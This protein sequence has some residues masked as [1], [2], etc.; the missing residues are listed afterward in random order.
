MKQKLKNK[1]LRNEV[2]KEM[3]FESVEDLDEDMESLSGE[4]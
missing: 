3:G 1:N 2:K 4:N